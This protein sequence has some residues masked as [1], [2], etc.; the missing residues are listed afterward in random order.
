M[1]ARGL[2]AI[3]CRDCYWAVCLAL[4][5]SYH[6]DNS[7]CKAMLIVKGVLASCG[8]ILNVC[9]VSLVLFGI[10]GSVFD[11]K[12]KPLLPSGITPYHVEG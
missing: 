10:N 11:P 7:L 9:Q 6:L 2:D 5:H 12:S 1:V 3:P 4:P 8:G